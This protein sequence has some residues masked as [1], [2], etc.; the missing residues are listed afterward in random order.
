M[1]ILKMA[2]R[3]GM[4]SLYINVS[5]RDDIGSGIASSYIDCHLQSSGQYFSYHNNNFKNNKLY[6]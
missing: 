5:L 1:S 6:R 4:M 3:S 2:F